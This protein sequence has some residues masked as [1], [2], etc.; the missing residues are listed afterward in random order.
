MKPDVYK[1]AQLGIGALYIMAK[2]CGG[3]LLEP[4]LKQLHAN[5]INRVVSLLEISE[6]NELKLDQEPALT[7]KHNM[8]FVS[9]P[10]KDMALPESRDAYLAFTK[11]LYNDCITGLNIVVHCRAGIGRSGIIAAGVLGQDG[12]AP[13]KA[14]EHISKQRTVRVPDTQQQ[15]DWVVSACA[16]D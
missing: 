14:F 11:R 5:G 8:E 15:I 3:A 6:Q 2:P 13:L 16:I 1:I 4:T 10:I 7:V 12:F 9:F